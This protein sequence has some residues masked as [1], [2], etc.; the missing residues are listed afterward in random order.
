MPK[1]PE[2]DLVLHNDYILEFRVCKKCQE[3]C[4]GPL[5]AQCCN[6]HGHDMGTAG[7]TT[8][9]H[10]VSTAGLLVPTAQHSSQQED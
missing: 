7:V 10:L 9:E 3:A 1:N 4:Q 2:L 5:L 8:G 6:M